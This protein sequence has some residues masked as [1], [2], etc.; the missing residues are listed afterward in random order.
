M[1]TLTV[2]GL[3]ALLVGCEA[4]FEDLRPE[5]SAL[6]VDAGN[7]GE[8]APDS[9][10][11]DAGVGADL[12]SGADLGP[13][14][15]AVLLTS[16]SFER[17]GYRI[18]GTAEVFRLSDGTLELR[19]GDDFSSTA[20]PGPVVVFSTRDRIGSQID[21]GQGDIRI[22]AL[23]ANQGAQTYV[24]PESAADAPFLFIYCEPIGLEVGIA[25][26]TTGG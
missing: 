22:A 6:A 4:G 15:E 2:L 21:P 24:I 20:V 18:S 17:I 9:S 7:P 14:G 25:T 8:G 23:R 10:S 3:G 5:G 19:L 16:G 26:L 1:R 11:P 13:S 12:A